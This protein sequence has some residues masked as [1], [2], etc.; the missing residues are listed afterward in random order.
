MRCAHA[1]LMSFYLGSLMLSKGYIVKYILPQL[2][3]VK[4]INDLC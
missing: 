3:D 2:T 4:Q 1:L